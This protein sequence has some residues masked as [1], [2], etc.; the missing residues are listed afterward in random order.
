MISKRAAFKKTKN[1]TEQNKTKTKKTTTTT[2]KE[3]TKNTLT[4]SFPTKHNVIL[5]CSA[6]NVI[7]S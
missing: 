2:N 3:T 5:H 6:F 7:N 1:R 4:Y